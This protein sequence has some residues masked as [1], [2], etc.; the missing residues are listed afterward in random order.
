MLR[1]LAIVIAL[2][3]A[4]HAVHADPAPCAPAPA[5]PTLRHLAVQTDAASGG[6]LVPA[7]GSVFPAVSDD[8]TIVVDLFEDAT[9]FVGTPVSTLAT[10][11]R[12]GSGPSVALEGNVDSA[13]PAQP[14]QV[15]AQTRAMIDANALLAKHRWRAL[16]AGAICPRD[17]DD[18]E[19]GERVE[20]DGGL[21]VTFD[22]TADA[23]AVDGRAVASHFPAPG[24]SEFGGCGRISGVARAY[25]SR[26]LGFIV[27]EPTGSL[28]GDSCTGELGVDT[29][30]VVPIP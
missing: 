18:A 9:D 29:T 14:D 8:G 21:H 5:D 24:S 2:A 20:L 4:A 26:A 27:L 15:Q 30:I 19:R 12:R 10:F 13:T 11:T 16:S 17:P 7:P 3:A 1:A 22:P 28:G 25:G 23:I 6:V